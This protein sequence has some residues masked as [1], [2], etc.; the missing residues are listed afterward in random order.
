MDSKNNITKNDIKK[1]MKIFLSTS[2]FE[3]KVSKIVKKRLKDEKELED[4]IVEIT[5][6]V[7]TQLFKTLWVKRATWSNNLTNKS[8]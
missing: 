6:N 8:N 3:D 2:E 4:K 7:I 5:K 1:E